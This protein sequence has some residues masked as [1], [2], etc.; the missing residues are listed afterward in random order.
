MYFHNSGIL[1]YRKLLDVALIMVTKLNMESQDRHAGFS[2]SIVWLIAAVILAIPMISGCTKG[3]TV[4][5]PPCPNAATSLLLITPLIG[6]ENSLRDPVR[7]SY[8]HG[9]KDGYPYPVNR[10]VYDRSIEILR[11]AL[12][13]A[14]I[15]HNDKLKAF[16][17]LNVFYEP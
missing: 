12:Q 15:G 6:N 14:K 11:K 3:P 2:F 4:D 10:R 17:R 7:F 16:K 9:G 13:Q 1:G 5:I 8:A